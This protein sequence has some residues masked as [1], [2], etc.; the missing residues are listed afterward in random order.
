MAAKKR[1]TLIGAAALF[2]LCVY[3]F[4]FLVHPPGNLKDVK[5][6]QHG[7]TAPEVEGILGKSTFRSDNHP[8][9]SPPGYTLHYELADGWTMIS[10]N[11]DDKVAYVVGAYNRT[12]FWQSIMWLRRKE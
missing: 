10:Y 4:P 9:L 2:T 8:T 5:R 6:I 11:G 3:L 1:W 7:M 12:R